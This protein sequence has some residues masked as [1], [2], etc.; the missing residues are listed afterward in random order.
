MLKVFVYISYGEKKYVV[1]GLSSAN[2]TVIANIQAIL[3][4]H[5]IYAYMQA[6]Q[7]YDRGQEKEKRTRFICPELRDKVV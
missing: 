4:D 3:Y 5:F 7:Y 2:S 6:K 1:I